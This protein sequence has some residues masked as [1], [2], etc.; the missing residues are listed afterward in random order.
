MPKKDLKHLK[1]LKAEFHYTNFPETSRKQKSTTCFCLVSGKFT[2]SLCG[3]MCYEHDGLV[4]G[5]FLGIDELVVFVGVSRRNL[6]QV[7]K[8]V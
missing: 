6:R 7:Y 4:L 5:K 2:T 3:G 1:T 8:F